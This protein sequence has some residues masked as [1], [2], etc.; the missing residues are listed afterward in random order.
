MI[1]SPTTQH[2]QSFNGNMAKFKGVS[3][4]LLNKSERWEFTFV[5]ADQ[6]CLKISFDR[7]EKATRRNLATTLNSS[8]H[9]PAAICLVKMKSLLTSFQ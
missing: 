1:K 2:I 5:Y 4:E 8:N 3:M 6:V 7:K 9:I